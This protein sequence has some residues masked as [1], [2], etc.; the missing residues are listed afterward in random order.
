MMPKE[1]KTEAIKRILGPHL[2]AEMC[3]RFDGNTPE[4]VAWIGGRLWD[5]RLR[6]M[7]WNNLLKEA[8]AELT[9]MQD[10][11]CPVSHVKDLTVEEAKELFSKAGWA[12]Q[13]IKI[14]T[15]QAEQNLKAALT[16]VSPTEAEAREISQQ[17]APNHH[18]GEQP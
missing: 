9:A 13:N 11:A 10:L 5:G 15:V 14:Q 4:R 7:D 18:D 6:L 3:R 12:M 1:L 2:W 8:E 16:T 17:H